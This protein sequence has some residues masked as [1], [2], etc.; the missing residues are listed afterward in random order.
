[1]ATPIS[2]NAVQVIVEQA[3]GPQGHSLVGLS[4]VTFDGYPAVTLKLR[5]PDGREGLVHLSPIHGDT[6]KA[7]FTDIAAGTHCTLLCP[8]SGEPLERVEEIDDIF[9]AGYYRLYRT[10]DRSPGSAILISDVWG[11]YHSK[12]IDDFEIISAWADLLDELA[13]Q[14]D[15]SHPPKS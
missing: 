13:E 3:F 6:R 15:L 12:I 9:G 10:A 2:R 11:H 1:M 14:S 5:T 7:G 8:V 4:D